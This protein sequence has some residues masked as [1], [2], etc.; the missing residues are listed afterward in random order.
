ML[1]A[2]SLAVDR[3]GHPR[4]WITSAGLS[5]VALAQQMTP[6]YY[7]YCFHRPELFLLRLSL[8]IRRDERPMGSEMTTLSLP[9]FGL[10]AV[11]LAGLYVAAALAQEIGPCAAQ[12]Y[13]FHRSRKRHRLAAVQAG[14]WIGK[15][16][17]RSGLPDPRPSDCAKEHTLP[18]TLVLIAV[19]APGLRKCASCAFG[20]AALSAR[21]SSICSARQ[22]ASG[23]TEHE[24][25]NRLVSD[26]SRRRRTGC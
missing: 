4:R 10:L 21:H 13:R 6:K 25:A 17:H 7:T 1:A 15:M 11:P 22:L 5:P 16:V 23:Q 18:M 19:A 2:D 9:V 14:R 8:T 12:P 20:F 26:G 24:V 3:C